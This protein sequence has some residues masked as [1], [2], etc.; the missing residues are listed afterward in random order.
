MEHVFLSLRIIVVYL[1]LIYEFMVP[2]KKKVQFKLHVIN[3]R[4]FGCLGYLER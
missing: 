3:G 2:F 4:V 1:D